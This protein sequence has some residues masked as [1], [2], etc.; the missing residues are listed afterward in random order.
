[1]LVAW[2]ETLIARRISNLAEMINS[3]LTLC[4]TKNVMF[5]SQKIVNF[6]KRKSCKM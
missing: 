5:Y 1:V 2:L 4:A 6:R 3:K